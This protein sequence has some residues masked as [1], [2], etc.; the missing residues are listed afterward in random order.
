MTQDM[1]DRINRLLNKEEQITDET[2]SVLLDDL[3]EVVPKRTEHHKKMQQLDQQLHQTQCE[4]MRLEGEEA[5]LLRL[6][7]K[8]LENIGASARPTLKSATG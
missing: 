8:R 3:R 7:S 6:I 5:A 2:T 1:K 4:M